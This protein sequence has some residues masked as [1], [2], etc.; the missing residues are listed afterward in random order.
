V[1]NY[2]LKRTAHL[3]T[4]YLRTSHR[5]RRTLTRSAA[6]ALPTATRPCATDCDFFYVSEMIYVRLQRYFI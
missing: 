6:D 1:P 4:E 3:R 5:P 2:S